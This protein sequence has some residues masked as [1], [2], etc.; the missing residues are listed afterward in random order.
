M[1]DDEKVRRELLAQ[2][3]DRR[4]EKFD[5]TAKYI[6]EGHNQVIDTQAALAAM[7]SYATLIQSQER[8]RCAKIAEAHRNIAPRSSSVIAA[9]IRSSSPT[10]ER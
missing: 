1:T 4:G 7:S 2:E 10:Q 3:A 5:P 8:E 6:R 9:A